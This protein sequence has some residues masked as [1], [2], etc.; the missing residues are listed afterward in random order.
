HLPDLDGQ[1]DHERIRAEY[2]NQLAAVAEWFRSG[3]GV[4]LFA[5]V[6]GESVETVVRHTQRLLEQRRLALSRRRELERL[7][8]AFSRCANLDEAH[9][10]AAQA[11]ACAVPRHFLGEA[12]E[13]TRDEAAS[14]WK[15]EPRVVTLV[16]V[17]REP[18]APS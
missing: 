9:R 2:R 13:I 1:K 12:E 14:A 4:D 11:F 6:T 7:A 16:P 18:R 10:L 5:R 8:L 17:R 15:R 3:G